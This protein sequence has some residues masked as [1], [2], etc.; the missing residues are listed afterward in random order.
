MDIVAMIVFVAAQMLT[1]SLQKYYGT[2]LSSYYYVN[3]FFIY[4]LYLMMTR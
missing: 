4:Y 1:M 3:R 2:R